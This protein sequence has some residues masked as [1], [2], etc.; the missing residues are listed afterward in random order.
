MAPVSVHDQLSDIYRDF[1]LMDLR[2]GRYLMHN[3]LRYAVRQPLFPRELFPNTTENDLNYLEYKI[4][5]GRFA[6]D[7]FRVYES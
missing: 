3:A 7:L 6:W 4:R 5:S 2:T 1:I